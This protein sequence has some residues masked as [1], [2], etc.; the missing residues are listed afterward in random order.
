MNEDRI[1]VKNALLKGDLFTKLSAVLMGAGIAG[2]RQIIKGAV[3]LLL[4]SYLWK[5]LSW[6]L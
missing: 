4:S 6:G 1:T 5:S 3:V 2:H